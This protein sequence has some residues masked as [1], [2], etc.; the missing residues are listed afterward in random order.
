MYYLIY[1]LLY[2]MSLLPM[3]FLYGFADILAALV[4]HVIGYRRKVVLDNITI[5]FPEKS[6]KERKKIAKQFY[7]NFVDNFIETIKLLSASKEWILKRFQLDSA[8]FETF[9]DQGRKCQLHLGHN[10]NWEMANVSMPF[11]T[12]HKFL[13]V[14]MPIKNKA[15]ERLFMHLRTRTGS[16]MLPATN[17]RTAIVPFRHTN[18]VLALVADQAPGSPANA[19]WLNFFGKPTPFVRGPENGARIANIPV[20]FAQIYKTRRGYYRVYLEVGA[21]NPSELPVGELTRRYIRFL[22]NAIR[23]HPEM[24][25]WSHRRWKHDWKNEYSQYWIDND[26]PPVN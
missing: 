16:T 23:E 7:R 26:P 15:M 8:A 1:G 22:E 4:Y 19:Y 24:W 10:F 13:V 2:L 21:E 5:A 9:L 6:L 18:Y 25:L 11:F 3:W 17:M 14:Y 12:K 20:V